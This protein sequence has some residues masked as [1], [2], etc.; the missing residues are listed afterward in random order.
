MAILKA[1][2]TDYKPRDV[3]NMDETTLFWRLKQNATLWDQVVAG[4]KDRSQITSGLCTNMDD[5]HQFPPRHQQVYVPE[6]FHE[7]KHSMPYEFRDL[8]VQ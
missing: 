5:S 2:I 3:F 6:S 1:T 8:V 4:E 7:K